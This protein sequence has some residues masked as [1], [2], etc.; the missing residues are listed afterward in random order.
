MAWTMAKPSTSGNETPLAIWLSNTMTPDAR[1][2]AIRPARNPMLNRC[3]CDKD[4]SS[5]ATPRFCIIKKRVASTNTFYQRLHARCE[6]FLRWAGLMRSWCASH[7]LAIKR[8]PSFDGKSVPNRY[9][10]AQ[11]NKLWS[12]PVFVNRVLALPVRDWQ[13]YNF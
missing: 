5:I 13:P 1:I 9:P 7:R 11:R 3:F 8:N 2:P 4:G 10:T 12:S 6:E